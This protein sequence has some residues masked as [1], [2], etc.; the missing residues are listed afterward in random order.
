MDGTGD[1]E[2]RRLAGDAD[3]SGFST[4]KQGWEG[5]QGVMSGLVDDCGTPPWLQ[6]LGKLSGNSRLRLQRADAI[7]RGW[8]KRILVDQFVA[9][10]H[11]RF[12]ED[13]KTHDG[14]RTTLSEGTRS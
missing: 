12:V 11:S 14:Q 13:I 4:M 6:R 9:R 10:R 8:I 2:R 1:I 3:F 5:V 7:G